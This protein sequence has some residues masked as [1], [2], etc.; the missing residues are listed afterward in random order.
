MSTFARVA[1]SNDEKGKT[2]MASQLAPDALTEHGVREL[3]SMASSEDALVASGSL[4]IVGLF[5]YARPPHSSS[6]AAALLS[7]ERARELGDELA[8]GFPPRALDDVY[9]VVI[10]DGSDTIKCVLTQE[11]NPLVS[12]GALRQGSVVRGEFGKVWLTEP[13]NVDDGQTDDEP[14]FVLYI[15]SLEI[16]SGADYATACFK[17][18]RQTRRPPRHPRHD[19][20]AATGALN[21]RELHGARHDAG[22]DRGRGEALA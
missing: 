15:H 7:P 22:G 21:E 9:D 5:R 4:Q 10:S 12:R 18:R 2:Q 16:L 13:P 17:R 14:T 11:L 1:C 20:R 8:E 19:V 6:A 3:W